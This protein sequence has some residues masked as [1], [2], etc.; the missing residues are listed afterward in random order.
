[1]NQKRRVGANDSATREKLLSVAEQLMVAEGYAAV[2]SRRVAQEAGVT[3]PLVHYYF[4]SMDDLFVELMQR[5]AD[6]NLARQE[7]ALA[8]PNP[9]LALWRLSSHPAG[10][11]ATAE[12]A[13]LALKRKEIRAEIARHAVRFRAQQIDVLRNLAARG[14]LNI[15]PDDVPGLVVT[16]TSLGRIVGEE[17]ELGISLGHDE[18]WKFL[19]R[20]VADVERPKGAG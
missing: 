7:K 9:L 12:F 20:L 19:S 5:I 4:R 15:E 8:S 18:A 2:T 3:A 17:H 13:S 10:A 6:E 16:L 14:L 1:M 11:A